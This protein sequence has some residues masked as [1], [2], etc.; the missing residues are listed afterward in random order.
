MRSYVLYIYMPYI[1]MPLEKQKRKMLKRRN[2]LWYFLS[3]E[4]IR[5]IKQISL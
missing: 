1:D 3:K 2:I 4:A 5:S